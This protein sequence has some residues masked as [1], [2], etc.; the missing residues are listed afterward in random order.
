MHDDQLSAEKAQQ[1]DKMWRLSRDL[2]VVIDRRWKILAVNPAAGQLLGYSEEEAIGRRFDKFMHPEDLSLAARS[3]RAAASRPIGDFEARLCSKDGDWRWFSWSVA[4]GE[5][6]AF[7]IGRDV[8][9]ERE[10]RR[11]L[12]EAKEQLLH[13]QKMDTL[14]QLTGGVA[15]DFNNLLTTVLGGL[16]LILTFTEDERIAR[17]AQ[18]A[19]EAAQRGTKLTSQLL[20]FS[21]AQHLESKPVNVAA[22]IEGMR[23]LL[24]RTL[25][26]SVSLTIE[27]ADD[28]SVV[29]ADAVQLELAV[30]NLAINGRDAMPGG[31]ELKISILQHFVS[32]DR[33]LAD[34]DYVEI[35][36]TDVGSGM[37]PEV[38]AKAF[39]PFFTT[40]GPG[41]GTGLGLSMVYGV[42]KQSGG[43]VRIKSR[44][45]LTSVSMLLPRSVHA[46]S[47]VAPEP[48]GWIE[49]Q[50][51][52]GARVLLVDDDD[53]VR[54]SIADMLRRLGHKVTDAAEGTAAVELM[55]KTT[56]DLLI[57]DFA[58]P[59][60]SGAE[61]A[62][63]ARQV[64]DN[65]P[66]LFVTGY[67]ESARL[68]TS[69][70]DAAVLR[71]PFR[72]GALA[73]A[74]EKSL[75]AVD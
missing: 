70:P 60:M 50:V 37:A 3:I 52:R 47:P 74:V 28:T 58:M 55:Q 67:A 51:T 35:Q 41:K 56:F 23:N 18:T 39:D 34:G 46:A 73:E 49:Q 27:I 64:R 5:G 33:E 8:T 24:A 10:R 42:A 53:D 36:V 45:G 1:R 44:P 17:L 4:P 29:M 66:I 12:E 38:A 13:A 63:L 30:L 48:G 22:I 2:F 62:K 14:G 75:V 61:V 72:I 25:G 20:C 57:V 65:Q 6:E 16:D 31:G 69:A 19:M 59:Q 9:A 54:S 71:K 26:P 43:G 21:R 68:E 32:N 15:H 11:E 7:V 40:K